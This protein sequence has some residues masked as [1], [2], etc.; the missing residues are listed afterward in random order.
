[1]KLCTKK[2]PTLFTF[3][4]YAEVILDQLKHGVAK[5][6]LVSC[7]VPS[8]SILN[9]QTCPTATFLGDNSHRFFAKI[10]PSQ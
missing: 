1:M 6:E 7:P 9:S 5:F 8:I 2:V 10:A 3:S 4:I